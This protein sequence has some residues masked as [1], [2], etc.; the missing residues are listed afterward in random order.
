MV[1]QSLR[2]LFIVFPP[3]LIIILTLT[4]RKIQPTM[5]SDSFLYP[6]SENNDSFFAPPPPQADAPSPESFD[7]EVDNE[8]GELDFNWSFDQFDDF[9]SIYRDSIPVNPTPALTSATD[10]SYDNAASQYSNDF[11]PS[12]YSNRSGFEIPSFVNDGVYT[13]DE[14]IHSAMISDYQPSF[15]A[16]NTVETQTD[17]GTSDPQKFVEMTPGDPPTVQQSTFPM[18]SEQVEPFKPFKCPQCPFC[19][20]KP[21]GV[22]NWLTRLASLCA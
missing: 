7:S 20:S 11:S 10:S 4:F 21:A 12:V 18:I 13:I 9:Y 16:V 15:P 3:P 2:V 5:S 19:M 8:V 6:P 22:Y 14:F 1:A 17:N